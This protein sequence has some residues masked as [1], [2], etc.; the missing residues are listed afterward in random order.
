MAATPVKPRKTPPWV[1]TMRTG[2]HGQN[3]EGW[4][5]REIRGHIQ[6]SVRFDDG[7]RSTV[8]TT[9]PWAGTS[10][11]PLLT[12]AARIKELMAKGHGPR[13][14]YELLTAGEGVQEAGTISWP[15]VA[16]RFEAK[17]L[18][19]GEVK[20]RTW[21]RMY[22]PVVAQVIAAMAAKPRPTTGKQLLQALVDAHG[23]DPG[24]RGRQTRIQYASQLLRFGVEDCAADG[25]WMPPANLTDLVGKKAGGKA[26][27]VPIKDHQVAH[28]LE[29]ISNPQWRT[30]VGL[31]ACFGLRGVELGY[32]QPKGPL[33]HCSYQK[34]TSRGSTKPRDIVGL[35]PVGL[36]GLGA[37]LLALLEEQG[38]EALPAGCRGKEGAG[39]ALHQ[40][41][42]RL[43][44]WKK[45]V[46]ET[47]ELN[48]QA[49]VPYSLRHGYALRAHEVYSHS[50]RVAAALMGHSL[51]THSAV[52]GAWTDSEVIASALARTMAAT[53]AR[54]KQEVA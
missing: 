8:V 23:G 3:G 29:A 26:P 6:L 48:D 31:V 5:V 24:S 15:A 40:Y 52:Y 21:R 4:T 33:L 22:A 11:A 45:L 49:L 46:A 13:E 12:T 2:L 50:P 53:A 19:S 38:A 27:T 47:A 9:L 32:I 54:K 25:R 30:A 37:D 20:E 51:Q 39:D 10:Q 41:L 42:E 14:A 34:R 35:D 16:E 17:K 18:G 43:P 28:L 36:E 7:A 1:K 44:I